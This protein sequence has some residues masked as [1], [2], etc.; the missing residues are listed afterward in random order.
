MKTLAG[1]TK[2]LYDHDAYL[3]EFEATVIEIDGNNVILD[4]TL[5]HPES[6][7]Q[8]GDTGVIGGTNVTDT[9]LSDGKIVHLLGSPP[10]LN[11]GDLVRGCLAWERRYKIM[12]LHS[13]AHIMEFFLFREFGELKRLGSFVDDRKDRAD[14]EFEGKIPADRLKQV[15]NE[16]NKFLAEDHEITIKPDHKKPE[17]RIWRCDWMEMPCAGTHVRSTSEIGLIRLK[18]KNP[19]RG[20]ERIETSLLTVESP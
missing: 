4:Q 2:K 1:D 5:F 20:V 15:E 13:A 6:G 12:K 10:N 17:I 11:V 9:K 14:Y 3:K 19:G 18:R 7:G 16:T 8:A